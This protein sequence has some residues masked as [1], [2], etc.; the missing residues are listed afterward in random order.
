MGLALE[1]FVS[2]YSRKQN[3][4]ACL[5]Q[6]APGEEYSEACFPAG[7]L[8]FPPPHITDWSQIWGNRSWE[9]LATEANRVPGSS[10]GIKVATQ[11]PE[12]L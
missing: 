2:M 11:P 4:N 12:L 5:G 10:T 9:R 7:A 1:N 6:A 8:Y 3:W